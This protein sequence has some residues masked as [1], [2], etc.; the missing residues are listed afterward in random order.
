[1]SNLESRG[2]RPYKAWWIAGVAVLVA[3][4]SLIVA[5]R[6]EFSNHID[7][8]LDSMDEPLNRLKQTGLPYG[9]IMPPDIREQMEKMLG[10]A[11]KWYETQDF[12]VGRELAKKGAEPH[13]PVVLLPGI[14]STGLES[15]STS[16]EQSPFFRKRLWGSTSMIQRALFDKDHWVRNL[17][18]DPATGLDPEGIRVR[19]AQGLDA[20]SYF[21]AGYWVW[22]KII[23]NLAAVGYDINQLYLASYDW[24]LSMFN[25]EE[26]DRFFSRIMSQI[27]F[28]TLAYGKK[29]VLISHSMGGTVALY[30]LKWVER[31]RGSSWIDEHLEAF[32][33]LSGTLLGVPKAM[34]ALMTG[35]MRDTVQA[36]AMLAY[37][38]ERFFSAQERAELF[39]SWAGSASLIPKGGNAVWGDEHGAPDDLAN[40]TK[41]HGIMMEY[42]ERHSHGNETR[43]SRKLSVDEV[44]PWLRM[45]SDKHFQKMLHSN[46]SFGI[47]RDPAQIQ[48]NNADPTKWTNPLEVALPY[49]P[50]MKI[51]CVYGWNQPTERSYW[52]RDVVPETDASSPEL[53]ES[54]RSQ[55]M[56]MQNTSVTSTSV[57]MSRIDGTMSD[58]EAVPSIDS[59]VRVGEG[60]GTVPLLSL[61]SMCSRGWKMDRYNP[62]RMRVVTHEVKH[63]PEA[64]D[65][66]GGDSSG[67]HIDILG[68]HDLNEAVVKIATGLGDSVPE[69]IFSPIQSYADKIQ[70]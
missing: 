33:N 24:R 52:M 53:F 4:V 9:N 5:R 64:F 39:R 1:M 60:D 63:D 2:Q 31:K 50:N 16:E 19:A 44:Y 22:S 47:E 18:L 14:V 46:Y 13:H 43:P 23:E 30:F 21:A 69:R 6:A 28:H 29:T 11:R 26:R 40:A 41:T 3:V 25:L 58:H 45:H 42:A 15:W 61:G 20:A 57:P 68:S 17:M 70:W 67:D 27:E 65:L 37:L 62:A 8:L 56:M 59:G 54:S 32:V 7:L 35:E 48:A 12:K 10:S 55:T 36:P 51:Y 49:A 34:P 38:L 66:R